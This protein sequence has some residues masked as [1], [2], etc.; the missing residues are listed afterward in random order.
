ML[1]VL[2][3]GTGSVKLIRGLL[4]ATHEDLTII[5]NVGDNFWLHGLYICPDVDIVTYALASML[6]RERGWGVE[7]DKFNTLSQIEKLGGETWFKLGDRD[8]AT[9]ILRTQLMKQGRKL[10]EVTREICN[11]L[12]VKQRVIPATDDSVETWINTP[13]GKVHLQEYWV[14]R[15]AQ[16]EVLGV[17]YVGAESAKASPEVTDAI[18]SANAILLCP[19]N[20]VTSIGPILAVKQIRLAISDTNAERIAV[21]PIIGKAP[22][23]GPA[24]KMMSGLGI[25]VS[26][27]GVARLYSGLVDIFVADKSDDGLGE[28]LRRINVKPVFTD[29][30]M[31]TAAR[32]LELARFVLRQLNLIGQVGGH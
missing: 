32:E 12:G 28:A 19:A 25:E 3:G 23:S 2:A 17:T 7:G 27:I 9:H 4:G 15:K 8:L 18:M 10:S 24:A 5:S 21:S 29:I 14:K 6:D 20:P 16:D 13:R 11:R 30:M 26:P 1:T 31:P 22:I